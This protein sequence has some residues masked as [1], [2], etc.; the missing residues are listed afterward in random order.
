MKP[1]PKQLEVVSG[2]EEGADGDERRDRP[3]DRHGAEHAEADRSGE[4][5][6][7]DR[8][9]GAL[10]EVSAKRSPVQLVERV[11]T[12]TDAEE[13]RPQGGGEPAAVEIWGGGGAERNVAQMPPRV[14]QMQERHEVAPAARAQRVE[15][16]SFQLS[17]RNREYPT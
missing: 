10:G 3:R 2:H 8:D 9:Q 5:D 4:R 11:R 6:H 14:G 17:G 7:G 15:G 13:E 12:E 16:G 1:S